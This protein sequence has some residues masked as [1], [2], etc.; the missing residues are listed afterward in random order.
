MFIEWWTIRLSGL[1]IMSVENAIIPFKFGMHN[2]SFEIDGK[3]IKWSDMVR[4]NYIICCCVTVTVLYVTS[5]V[6]ASK[7]IDYLEPKP[8]SIVRAMQ[9]IL[10]KFY[11]HTATTLFIKMGYDVAVD[12]MVS[13]LV[14]QLVQTESGKLLLT[15]VIEN[16]TTVSYQ[17]HRRSYN[18]F[19]VDNYVGFR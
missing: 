4:S 5:K 9:K 17:N 14:D 10:R 1:A 13:E 3:N 12:T 7:S 8:L 16:C 18:L 15:F 19:V 2:Q 6:L 11:Y